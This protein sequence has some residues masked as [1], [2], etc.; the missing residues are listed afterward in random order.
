MAVRGLSANE[1]ARALISMMARSTK[2]SNQR[3]DTLMQD[4]ISPNSNKSS[5]NARPDHTF[6]SEA[7]IARLPDNV[8]FTPES[9]QIA[10]I[11]VCPLRAK[12]GQSAP[13]RAS[14]GPRDSRR[15]LLRT[16]AAWLL[17]FAVLEHLLN[18]LLDCIEVEGRRV[19]HRRII[20]RRR[21]QLL[22][23]LLHHDEAP[24]LTGEELIHVAWCTGVQGLAAK[25]RRSLERVL[26]NVDQPRHVRGGLF[27]R[28]APRLH[29]ERELEVVEA[30]GAE[31][32]AAEIEQLAALGW[33]F[34]GEQIYLVIAVQMVLVGAI[35]ELHSFQQLIGD[36]RVARRGHERGKPIE[37]GEDS[38]LDGARLD[39]PR[40]AD[41]GRHAEAA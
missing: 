8:R 32:R 20:D 21:C 25:G 15:V 35:A 16:P 6:G 3:P 30:N 1:I 41:D 11:A 10:E 40:P 23:V 29:K 36:V 12:S 24:E 37:P 28:P 27:A 39:L 22:D 34:A 18:L 4:R 2:R 38:I 33:T 13:I 5:C 7:D 17:P 31:L 26:A 14:R 19:L 9:G